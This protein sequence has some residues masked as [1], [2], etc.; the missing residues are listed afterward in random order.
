MTLGV[1]QHA[2][3]GSGH[4]GSGSLRTR[5]KGLW[6]Q[7]VEIGSLEQLP[8]QSEHCVIMPLLVRYRLNDV[9]RRCHLGEVAATRAF[10]AT[11]RVSLRWMRRVKR[12]LN[13]D[14]DLI[15]HS[16]ASRIRRF[17]PD[18]VH[19]NFTPLLSAIYAATSA[20]DF[21]EDFLGAFGATT[22]FRRSKP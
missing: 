4:K 17:D 22:I 2:P 15:P 3:C 21:T 6:Q 11:R 12:S 10:G 8:A 1:G 20:A 18:H 14:L 5:G 9:P 19:Q 13:N 16:L 7:A